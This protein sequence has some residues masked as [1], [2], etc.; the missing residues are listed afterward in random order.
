ME[1]I[2]ATLIIIYEIIFSIDMKRKT[3][4][5]ETLVLLFVLGSLFKTAMSNAC[6][7]VTFVHRT[8]ETFAQKCKV[9]KV[10]DSL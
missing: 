6:A 10:V 8:F 7:I 5:Y 3:S 2:N 4:S 9:T 1:I